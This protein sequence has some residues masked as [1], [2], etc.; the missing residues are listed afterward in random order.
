MLRNPIT[1]S[2]VALVRCGLVHNFT[3]AIDT[4]V[5]IS[6][7]TR[8]S[9][10]LAVDTKCAVFSTLAILLVTIEVGMARL[11]LAKVTQTKRMTGFDVEGA[12]LVSLLRHLQGSL[13]C[14]VSLSD[15]LQLATVALDWTAHL[16]GVRLCRSRCGLGPCLRYVRLVVPTCAESEH[17]RDFSASNGIFLVHFVHRPL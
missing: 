15:S 10:D 7:G 12:N 1:T 16:G 8:S 4:R 6:L 13:L 14:R 17:L 9:L 2:W 11:V 5:N 3:R